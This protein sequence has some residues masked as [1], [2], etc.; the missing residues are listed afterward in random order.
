MVGHESNLGLRDSTLEADREP[1]KPSNGK[2]NNNNVQGE[3][4]G[5]NEGCNKVYRTIMRAG[6]NDFSGA[7]KKDVTR[8]IG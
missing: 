6:A 2:Q 3:K 5:E 8:S 4:Q 7:R 1:I